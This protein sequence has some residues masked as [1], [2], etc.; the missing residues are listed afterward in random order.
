MS[1]LSFLSSAYSGIQNAV[2]NKRQDLSQIASDLKAGN[3][4]GAEQT[5]SSL[6]P[7]GTS[8][9]GAGPIATDFA[10]LGKALSSGIVSQAQ[11]ALSQLSA[12]L[13]AKTSLG[14][15]NLPGGYGM[16]ITDYAPMV[17]PGGLN[18]LA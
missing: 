13:K 9:N 8:P 18:L 1:P 17:A 11:T 6:L 15:H 10:A 14:S 5:F 4:S 3:I 2:S 16:Q 7:S 12:D